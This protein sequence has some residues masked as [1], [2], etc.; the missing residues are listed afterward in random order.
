MIHSVLKLSVTNCY[1]LRADN[2]LVLIDTGY[3]WEW[4]RFRVALQNT[5]LISAI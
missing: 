5:A 3:D 2:G 1:L 4:E